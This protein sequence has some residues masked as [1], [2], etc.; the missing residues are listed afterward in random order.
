MGETLITMRKRF[1][2]ALTALLALVI[3]ACNPAKKYEEEEK[4]LIED[5]VADNNITVAPDANGIYYMEEYPG[6]GE[7]IQVGDS[8]G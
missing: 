3:V 8:V 1:S 6:T 2:V 7:L 5:Y 4:S